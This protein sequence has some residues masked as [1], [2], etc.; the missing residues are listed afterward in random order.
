ME[1]SKMV[2]Y[3]SDSLTLKINSKAKLLQAKG[4]N[5]INLSAGEPD[6]DTPS[7]VKAKAKEA[8]DR[9]YTKYTSVSGITPLKKAI[10]T[11]YRKKYGVELS[12]DSVLITSG[13]KQAVHNIV[14][15]LC[16]PGDEVIILVP[17]WLSYPEIVKISLS[18][19]VFIDT[20]KTEYILK[21]KDLEEAITKKTKLLILNSPCNPTGVVYPTAILR[22]IA[23][24]IKKRNI[25]CISDEIYDELIYDKKEGNSMLSLINSPLDNIIIANG[26]S[27]TF[28]M[29]GWRL[30]YA[31]ASQAI[32][33]SATKLQAHTTSCAS[34]ISQY[35]ALSAFEDA[36]SF[37]NEI[38]QTLDK[39]RKL[40]IKLLSTIDDI[41]F[42]E[43]EGAFYMF[44]D[45]SKFYTSRI[46]T[47]VE[48][49]EYLL[50]KCNVATVPGAA[51]GDDRHL[52]L[53]YALSLE[54]IEEG[55]RRIRNGLLDVRR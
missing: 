31:I 10:I 45:I 8:I 47:S 17:Y 54:K 41:S 40:A 48:M 20:S 6:L 25:H 16:G 26:V 5:V 42:P 30:G 35:A 21:P 1:F 24:I 27:K 37:I 22:E 12:V 53:S 50:D 44:I 9:G 28:S 4:I 55:I 2:R 49:S 13:T 7:I 29:T 52:R 19:P 43:P 51:F 39:R 15:T 46:S 33:K 38:R 32:I 36:E 11:R 3:L 14:E 34:S 23:S 18:K